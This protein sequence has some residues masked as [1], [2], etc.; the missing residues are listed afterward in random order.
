MRQKAG[1]IR[2]WLAPAGA[3]LACAAAATALAGPVGSRVGV[4]NYN[5]AT[6]LMEWAAWAGGLAVLLCAAGLVASRRQGRRGGVLAVAGLLVAAPVV[7]L[8]AYWYYL[9]A[10]TPPI[11][12]ITTD[13][14]RPPEFW[15]T[16]N[17]RVYGGPAVAALQREAYPDIGPLFTPL[18]PAETFD[19]ALALVR[20]RGWTIGVAS[21]EEGRIEATETTFWFGF[22]DDISIRIQPAPGGSR[23]DVR[24]TSRFGGG[25]DGGTN[26]RRVRAFLRDLRQR[27]GGE[28]RP[29]A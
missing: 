25:G 2:S 12:D 21:R 9:K 23:V 8:P 7:G 27:T 14:R 1:S 29:P 26:A 10:S 11:Q 24:S 16:P 5:F 20:D 15:F 13:V 4:W 3:A 22:S 6:V 18:P 19:R 17:A 28:I